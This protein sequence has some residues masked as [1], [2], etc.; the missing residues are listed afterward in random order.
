[1]L[2]K[3]YMI[4]RYSNVCLLQLIKKIYYWDSNKIFRPFIWMDGFISKC[5]Q[6]FNI[7]TIYSN[8]YFI[9]YL[10]HII[11]SLYDYEVF[12]YMYKRGFLVPFC[13][14]SGA[15]YKYLSSSF[16][17]KNCAKSENI[18]QHTTYFNNN[19]FHKNYIHKK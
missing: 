10:L 17:R 5:I 8:I 15:N 14:Y 13:F 9:L 16:V 6:F 4:K 12:W 11:E 3:F 18:F 7:N 19:Y 2:N 1:M